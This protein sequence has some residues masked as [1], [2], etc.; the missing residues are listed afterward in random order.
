MRLFP[1]AL[2]ILAICLQYLIVTSIGE[3][4]N[5]EQEKS[6]QIFKEFIENKLNKVDVTDEERE[7]LSLEN[8]L[9]QPDNK[10]M[11]SSNKTEDIQQEENLNPNAIKIPFKQ[12]SA[13]SYTTKKDIYEIRKKAV[14]NSIFATP[15]YQ[16]SE[17]V[18][19][20][21]VDYRPWV[22]MKMCQYESTGKSDI[23]GPSEEGRFIENPA[24]LVAPEYGFYGYSCEEIQKRGQRKEV[25]LYML[26]DKEKNELSIVYKHL[27]FCN[28]KK[29]PAWF[30]LN[31]LNARDLGYKY[32]FVDKAK[33]T[34]N[35]QFVEDYNASQFPYEFLNYIHLGHSCKHESGC[36]NGSPNQPQINFRYP[37][38]GSNG[39]FQ[40]NKMIYLKLWKNYPKSVGDKADIIVKII[41][42]DSWAE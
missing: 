4:P 39:K 8:N 37:C 5:K 17:E 6:G 28:P 34:F 14:A 23:E 13:L 11:V 2:L 27:V 22:S 25:P 31:G 7:A 9:F 18:F 21:I 36:N 32:V 42:Q 35:F 33:S 19:G 41:I 15:D 29:H 12:P 1:V 3:N 30:T 38:T 24:L 10:T 40:K 20:K 26:Y 16:P